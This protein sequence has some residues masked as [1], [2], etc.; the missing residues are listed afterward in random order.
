M[1]FLWITNEFGQTRIYYIFGT[2]AWWSYIQLGLIHGDR[3]G[4][5]KHCIIDIISIFQ[6]TW[7]IFYYHTSIQADTIFAHACNFTKIGLCSSRK[8]PHLPHRRDSCLTQI[9]LEFQFGFT[10]F[11]SR[12]LQ[13]AV[14]WETLGRRLTFLQNIS[15][16][17]VRGVWLLSSYAHFKAM[18][19][20][21]ISWVLIA[22]L[23]CCIIFCQE[24]E[25]V[26]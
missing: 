4:A 8:Y 10:H 22:T 26:C 12:S 2:A 1:F 14:R 21:V 17:S 15:V 25:I 9:P 18:L 11:L 20:Q 5:F 6:E 16:P 23:V 24:H 13:G 3:I 7:I 19:W